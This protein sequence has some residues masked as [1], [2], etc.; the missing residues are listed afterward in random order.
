MKFS[1]PILSVLLL[2]AGIDASPLFRAKPAKNET[3]AAIY[4]RR[5]ATRADIAHRAHVKE[6]MKRLNEHVLHQSRDEDGLESAVATE[7]VSGP[8]PRRRRV[9]P[10]AHVEAEAVAAEE[11][12]VQVSFEERSTYPKCQSAGA[13][14]GYA[15]YPGWKLV[16]DDVSL[17]RRCKRGN[18]DLG[19][20]VWRDPCPP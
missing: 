7:A 4:A 16:G 2:A 5:Q 17:V 10:R 9:A 14:T 18:A 8:L 1:V 20:A 3:L 12:G 15:H 19:T 13:R 11:T 6:T